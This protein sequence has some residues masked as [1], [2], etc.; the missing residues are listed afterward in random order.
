ML[1]PILSAIETQKKT[2]QSNRSRFLQNANHPAIFSTLAILLQL[3]L[4]LHRTDA[5]NGDEVSLRTLNQTF[6]LDLGTV[7]WCQRLDR[8]E[9]VAIPRKYTTAMVA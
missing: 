6:A 4:R 3:L 7:F 2:A 9:L 8:A 1:Q 5:R